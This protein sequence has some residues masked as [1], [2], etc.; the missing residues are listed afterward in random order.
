[1][2]ANLTRLIREQYP[3]PI[4][5]A[6]KKTLA[7][8][9]DDA[10]KLK[11]LIQTAETVIQ[12][13]ALVVLAQ[14]HRD[15]EQHQA[16]ALDARIMQL[17][18]T[19]RRPAFGTWHG[20]ARDVLKHYRDRR[21]LLVVPELFDV[22][23]QPS[24]G[25]TLRVQPVVRQAINPLIT[26]RNQFHHPEILPH[27]IPEH[28]DA[29][30]RWL[31]Q[32]LA[33]LRFLSTYQLAFIQDIKVRPPQQAPI[34]RHDLVQMRGCYTIFD[35]QR[36]D[37]EAYLE[38][39]RLILLVSNAEQRSLFLNPF[40]TCADQ[41]P[42]PGVFD[43]F[44]LNGTEARRARYRSTQFGQELL[45]DHTPWSQSPEHLE[46][47]GQFFDLLRRAPTGDA[48]V[49]LE[50]G[51]QGS[52]VLAEEHAERS[53]ETVYTAK[54]KRPGGAR[55][56]TSPYKFLDYFEPEDADL[57]FGRDREIRRLQ[58]KFH[59]AR[60]LILHGE[61]GTGKTS[62]IRA[63]LIPRLSPESYIPAYVRAWQEPTQAI[64]EA[65]VHQLGVDHRNLDMPL[66]EFLDAETAHLSKTVV[67]IL[68]QFEEFFLRFPREVRQRFH[69][70][71]GACMAASHLDVHVVLSLRDDYFARLGEFQ[72]TIPDIFTHEMYLARLTPEQAFLAAV[73]PVKRVGLSIDESMVTER[74]LPQ[75]NEGDQGIQPPLL[76]IVCDALYQRA[77]D[78]G[79]TAIGEEECAALGDIREVLGR[80][81]ERTLRQFGQER[82]QARAVLKAL[83]TAAGTKRAMFLE[84][85][86]SR[87]RTMGVE[88]PDDTIERG[89]VRKLVQARLVR[90]EV[91]EGRTR[92]ELT[93][94]FL[95]QQIAQW[96]A[97]EERE[98]TKVLE[99]IDRAYE[100]YQAT[101]V[102]L[103]RRALE[104]ITPVEDQ[105]VLS[106]E[107]QAFLEQS[108]QAVRH[109][110]WRL[111]RRVGT[112]F[113]LVTLGVVSVF[114]WQLWQ[115]S[116]RTEAQRKLADTARKQAEKKR[117]EALISQSKTLAVLSRAQTE[118]GNTT[119]GIL[120]VLEA[121]PRNLAVPDRPYVALAEAA[122]AHAVFN[123]RE[124]AILEGHKDIVD[125]AGF[126]RD[127]QHLVTVSWDT[128]RLWNAETGDLMATLKGHQGKAEGA[129]HVAFS[130]DNQRLVIAS[131][132][133][134]SDDK[135]IVRIWD[136]MTGELM[137]I[138][139]GHTE[140]VR[141][142][143][144]SP[145][146]Q[147][148]V[149]T[150][151]DNTEAVW[152][153]RVWDATTGKLYKSEHHPLKG[154]FEGFSPDSQRVVTKLNNNDFQVWDVTT[155]EPLATIHNPHDEAFIA[156]SPDGQRLVTSFYGKARVWHAETGELGFSLPDN[157]ALFAAFS[158]DGNYI[159]TY[160]GSG[161]VARLWDA[162]S[163]KLV[164]IMQEHRDTIVA[165]LFSPDSKWVITGAHDGT[166]RL[167]KVGQ[168]FATAVLNDPREIFVIPL[169]FSPDSK[170]LV[171]FSAGFTGRLWEVAT[172]EPSIV[173]QVPDDPA[174]SA[175]FSPDGRRIAT[176]HK[177]GTTRLW[178]VVSSDAIAT[179]P[180]TTGQDDNQRSLPPSLVAFSPDGRR[181]ISYVDHATNP[182]LHLP[183]QLWDA[184]GGSPMAIK[185]TA[186]GARAFFSPDGQRI[187][188]MCHSS[189]I[190]QS[191]G[192]HG[193][194]FYSAES[195]GIWNSGRLWDAETGEPIVTIQRE[196]TYWLQAT[197]SPDSR[198]LVTGSARLRVWNAET[199][200]LLATRHDHQGGISSVAF[201]PDGKR[202]LTTSYDGTAR[203]W[204]A[205]TT[206]TLFVLRGHQGRVW[207]GAFSPDGS[208][209][210]TAGEDDTARLWD[211][212]TGELRAV[213][214]DPGRFGPFV[215]EFSSDGNRILTMSVG[216]GPV[217]LWEGST[218][219]RIDQIGKRGAFGALF[220]PDGKRMVTLG[221]DGQHRLWDAASG[222]LIAVFRTEKPGWHFAE[223]SPDGRLMLITTRSGGP[224]RVWQLPP[225]GQALIDYAWHI[226][227]RQLMP[228]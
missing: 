181:G 8:L 174:T 214:E 197:F 118:A 51:N 211:T 23:F 42:V 32:L 165:A 205:E 104:V 52:V 64:K 179:L 140:S 50:E 188:T 71:L 171:T 222:A 154:A 138:L 65:M 105:L 228:E 202:L 112:L 99:L 88:L 146:S 73:E 133:D 153:V 124:K 90:A 60:L 126:S 15:L 121:L 207:H 24:R 85:L 145:G 215:A 5:Y 224:A 199:G 208:L 189:G 37:S 123:H 53:T 135:K 103:E 200:K 158:S 137:T 182:L 67:V 109:E 186:C 45:T 14:L 223:F 212:M 39:G 127:S 58:L 184:I 173:L 119:N 155:G 194:Q 56:Y 76:Q 196:G 220:S 3:F 113:L 38:P 47:L 101:G 36:W 149:T 160:S 69:Q 84:E 192:A 136:T 91:V 30:T 176:A 81:L 66:A 93:H 31:E 125:W 27:L 11:C 161:T 213:M 59:N 13:L 144:F 108:E 163:G 141:H 178:D 142:V 167:W 193:P 21:E 97:Q 46:A 201:S 191:E 221:G 94:E 54:Y 111:W 170:R 79:H 151:Y 129:Y 190:I 218:G 107:Q 12:F 185:K 172:G 61:S 180:Y 164:T 98:L 159:L 115:S 25:Q 35:R 206:E 195:S 152:Q 17:R 169:A 74:I 70:E 187:Y 226:V 19:L 18:D 43:V 44:L 49:E 102:L 130:P 147:Y 77:H 217:R 16:P 29:G 86:G 134:T 216:G 117:D 72:D 198:R 1:M 209:V 22:Y 150:S 33:A 131:S 227:P 63:G 7:L 116:Q 219:K 96:I 10:Q 175:M 120:L 143:A 100:G 92:Y 41:L 9:D 225:T 87:L 75:L 34:F 80:Y 139:E 62:L 6:Y 4:A 83:V 2:D 128:A 28:I 82:R 95:V 162:K 148:V 20:I 210:V 168:P 57:F 26:L 132:D 157:E 122:L 106:P 110:R 55:Q 156:F 183:L 40:I 78:A 114:S 203:I 166:A 68:D 204:D 177:S 89:F 48:E